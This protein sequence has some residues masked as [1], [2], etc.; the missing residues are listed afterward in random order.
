MSRQAGIW[1]D[2]RN[3]FIVFV[4][5]GSEETRR[6]NSEVEKHVRFSGRSASQEGSADDQRDRQFA[7]HLARYYDEVIAH[8][9][10][11][12]SILLFGP[13]EAKREFEKRLASEGLGERIVGIETT[14]K[15]TDHQ[16]AARVR[17]YF[18]K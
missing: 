12:E 9:R 3:A 7:V 17:Q 8:V 14:D 6:I 10:D 16:I 2:H 11:M 13:G 5:E 15:M 18:Q 1:I 4:G